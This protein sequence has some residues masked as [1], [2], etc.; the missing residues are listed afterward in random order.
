MS[1]LGD[2]IIDGL[3]E[4]MAHASGKD[5]GAH[6]TTFQVPD[7]KMI[8]ETLH[9]SQSEFAEAY[10]IPLATLQGWEQG[11]RNPDRTAAAYL[12]VIARIPAET[13][14]ALQVSQPAR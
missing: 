11:R 14:G 12:S 5:T 4:A 1:K 6:V 10:Q 2:E 13:R 8:R 9:M 3:T 7:V